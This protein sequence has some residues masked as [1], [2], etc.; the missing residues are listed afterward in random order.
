[1]PLHE[2]ALQLCDLQDSHISALVAGNTPSKTC[3]RAYGVY[4][5]GLKREAEYCLEVS[6][7]ISMLISACK[8]D[9]SADTAFQST[10]FPLLP[11]KSRD[12]DDD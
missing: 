5:H 11:G 1:M 3:T 10:I 4:S 6:M 9:S 2:A 12:S 8:Q 7:F